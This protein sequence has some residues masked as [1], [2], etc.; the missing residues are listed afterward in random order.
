MVWRPTNWKPTHT[1]SRGELTS[2]T[3]LPQAWLRTTLSSMTKRVGPFRW[4]GAERGRETWRE[5]EK[6]RERERVTISKTKQCVISLCPFAGDW[7]RSYS[8]SLLHHQWDNGYLQPAP[9]TNTQSD[10]AV[11]S[12]LL[13]IRV[14]VHHCQRGK[15]HLVTRRNTSTSKSYYTTNFT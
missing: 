7:S 1:S 8:Q 6:W 5:R 3:L 2:S 9:Q 13:V 4:D 11:S 12:V 14:Q 15:Q 10:W